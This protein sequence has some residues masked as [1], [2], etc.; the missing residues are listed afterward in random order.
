MI[1]TF[2][3]NIKTTLIINVG[4]FDLLYVYVAFLAEFKSSS[5]GLK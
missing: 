1:N 5:D 2:S 3:K 4:P